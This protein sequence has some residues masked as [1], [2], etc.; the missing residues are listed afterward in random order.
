MTIYGVKQNKERETPEQRKHKISK[1]IAELAK[2]GKPID[3][4]KE[5]SKNLDDEIKN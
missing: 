4:L 3:A 2:S 1:E 5:K